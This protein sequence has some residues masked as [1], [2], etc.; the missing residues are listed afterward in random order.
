MPCY[1]ISYKVREFYMLRFL[2]LFAI[3]MLSGMG[4]G[5]GGLLIIY[6][7]LIENSPQLYAQGMNLFFFLMSAGASLFIHIRRRRINTQLLTILCITG[8]MGALC[9]SLL[10]RVVPVEWIRRIFGIMLMVS[11][12]VV[13][14]GGSFARRAKQH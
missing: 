3:A 1:T 10:I 2:I 12:G 9:G 13:L 7:T 14:F 6:L 8:A 5:G 4:V 11:G